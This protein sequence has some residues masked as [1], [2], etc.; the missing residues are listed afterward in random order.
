MLAVDVVCRLGDYPGHDGCNPVD[1]QCGAVHC[2]DLPSPG[3]KQQGIG[4]WAVGFGGLWEPTW[5]WHWQQLRGCAMPARLLECGACV[6][7]RK[8]GRCA[9]T[10]TTHH[11]LLQGRPGSTLFIYCTYIIHS[12]MLFII[13]IYFILNILNMI[14][15]LIYAQR[16]ACTLLGH[17]R[18]SCSMRMWH[19]QY[20]DT[21][22]CTSCYL[23]PVCRCC[24]TLISSWHVSLPPTGPSGCGWLRTGFATYSA[25]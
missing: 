11:R 14:I 16:V 13:F 22:C 9:V 10:E 21:Y 5:Q 23:S 24:I 20:T 12:F 19:E 2:Y 7:G 18:R 15:N 6:R 3:C 25:S 1:I 17:L 4:P 8:S